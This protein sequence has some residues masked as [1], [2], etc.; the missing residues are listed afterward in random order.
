MSKNIGK[1]YTLASSGK[2]LFQNKRYDVLRWELLVISNSVTKR[3][4]GWVL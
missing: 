1:P 4:A 2:E 3:G